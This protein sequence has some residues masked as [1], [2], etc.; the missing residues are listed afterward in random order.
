MIFVTGP[1]FSGK[2][3]YI[4]RALNWSEE[5]FREKGIR[6]VQELA[7]HTEETRLEALAERLSGNE[8]V[9][10]TEIGGGI[11]PVDPKERKARE[12]AGRLSCLLARKADTVVRVCCG[13]PL[14]MK[15]TMP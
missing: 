5:D 15:G 10:S 13:L 6:D 4:C 1:L 9:L 11:V 7:A 14:V 12:K 3:E 8:V 2:Q